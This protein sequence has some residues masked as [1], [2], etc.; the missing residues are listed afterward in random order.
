MRV[1]GVVQGHEGVQGR[2]QEGLPHVQH[3][4]GHAIVVVSG[5]KDAREGMRKDAPLTA[6]RSC[7]DSLNHLRRGRR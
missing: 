3:R 2:V 4:A 5:K 6:Q 7:I 1:L